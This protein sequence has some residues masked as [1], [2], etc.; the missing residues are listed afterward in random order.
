MRLRVHIVLWSA[1]AALLLAVCIGV[2]AHAA[3]V[4]EPGGVF[5]PLKSPAAISSITKIITVGGPPSAPRTVSGTAI[6]GALVPQNVRPATVSFYADGNQVGSTNKRPFRYDWDTTAVAEGEH[7]VKVTAVDAS[8]K[9][10]WSGETKVNVVHKAEAAAAKPS[11]PMYKPTIKPAPGPKPAPASPKVET[12]NSERHKFQVSYPAGWALTNQTDKMKPKWPGGFWFVFSHG[13]AKKANIAINLRHRTEPAPTTADA[14]AKLP[15]NDF[16]NKWQRATVNGKEAFRTTQGSPESKRVL[17]R[18][19]IVD[20]ADIW[21]LNCIDTTGGQPDQ[22]KILFDLVVNSLSPLTSSKAQ[23][24]KKLE[25]KPAPLRPP[26]P[27]T[28]PPV[29]DFSDQ[30]PPAEEDSGEPVVLE[31]GDKQ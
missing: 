28:P 29:T 11:V 7:T 14:F 19:L 27:P 16:L 4:D 1:V 30:P 9:E 24:P 8:G 18:C 15:E 6:I 20:G 22:S 5:E 23:P 31:G 21:M 2:A 3:K 17:H 10:V 25:P 12:L 26:T 13:P